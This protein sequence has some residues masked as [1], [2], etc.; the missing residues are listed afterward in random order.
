MLT[1]R[2]FSV[3]IIIGAILSDCILQHKAFAGDDMK[4]FE[5]SNLIIS[6]IND[7]YSF[8]GFGYTTSEGIIN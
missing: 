5:I 7:I 1:K 6:R 2:E 3:K 4:K 8:R